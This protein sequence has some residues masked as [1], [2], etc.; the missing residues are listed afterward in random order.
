[1]YVFYLL[2]VQYQQDERD[3]YENDEQDGDDADP[4]SQ[5][6]GSGFS[7]ASVVA[8]LLCPNSSMFRIDIAT[9]RRMLEQNQAQ[10]QLIQSLMSENQQLQEMK[11]QKVRFNHPNRTVLFPYPIH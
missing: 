1:L 10:K 5:S 9:A 3:S 2:Y 6:S 4:S 7:R 11:R 8:R